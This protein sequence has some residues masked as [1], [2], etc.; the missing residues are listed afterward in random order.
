MLGNHLLVGGPSRS[1][2]CFDV[3]DDPGEVAPRGAD[4]CGK[5]MREAAAKA[6]PT[7]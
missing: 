7:P 6:F 3:T 1:W 5:R 4:R 2:T